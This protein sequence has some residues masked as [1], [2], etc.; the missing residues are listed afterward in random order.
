M[1]IIYI[2]IYMVYFC[3]LWLCF[4]CCRLQHAK[5]DFCSESRPHQYNLHWKNNEW[6]EKVMVSDEPAGVVVWYVFV[7][8]QGFFNFPPRRQTCLFLKLRLLHCQ[9]EDQRHV[10]CRR[11]D[12]EDGWLR[13][14]PLKNEELQ[15]LPFGT[16]PKVGGLWSFFSGG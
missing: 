14:W 13:D 8:L 4:S 16:L 2:K 5:R 7:I 12:V 9:E 1:Y 6:K 10:R 11:G 15:R 3:L